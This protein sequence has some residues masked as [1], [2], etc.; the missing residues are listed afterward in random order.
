M[1][2]KRARRAAIFLSAL[3]LLGGCGKGRETP[4][5]PT[6]S[7]PPGQEA[8]SESAGTGD[9]AP[10]GASL[11][12]SEVAP[13]NRSLCP[14]ADG[15]FPDYLEI[16]NSGSE[17]C[18]LT[19]FLLSQK[20][21]LSGAWRFPAVTLAGASVCCSA[22]TESTA[23]I[24]AFP[25]RARVSIWRTGRAERSTASPGRS[26]NTT[27]YGCWMG[28]RPS[29]RRVSPPPAVPTP[30]SQPRSVLSPGL[31]ASARW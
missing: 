10:S 18:D 14:G 26:C 23:P 2:E 30:G 11:R 16:W 13:A 4:P 22:A 3:L 31:F 25:E 28:T 15:S 24:S 8:Q 29:P 19:G 27:R 9:S 6:A 21:S 7:P 1:K 12:I 5:A 17:S 20:A